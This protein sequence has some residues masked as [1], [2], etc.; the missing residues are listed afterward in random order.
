MR[1]ERKLYDYA[2]EESSKVDR[3]TGGEWV[4]KKADAQGVEGIL[5]REMEEPMKI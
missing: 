2:G 1:V 4:E 5:R 3:L